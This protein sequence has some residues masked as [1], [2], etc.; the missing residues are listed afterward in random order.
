MGNKCY[1][2]EE[3]GEIVEHLLGN[4]AAGADWIFTIPTGY[5]YTPLL[6]FYRFLADANVATR[7]FM[8]VTYGADA[9]DRTR[10]RFTVNG[11]ATLSYRFSLARG[12]MAADRTFVSGVTTFMDCLPRQRYISGDRWGSATTGI[13]V[14][15][16]YST[17]QLLA[18]RWKA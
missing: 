13:Q 4:P 17:I 2:P 6:I 8:F 18:L 15:D 12:N 3:G 11:A 14:G 5:E 16:Q 9:F 1:I 10:I 7:Y